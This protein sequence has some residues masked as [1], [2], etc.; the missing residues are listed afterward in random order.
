MQTYPLTHTVQHISV[1]N[2]A[3]PPLAASFSQQKQ[4]LNWKKKEN[5]ITSMH[6]VFIIINQVDTR[7][8]DLH[9]LLFCFPV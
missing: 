6:L 9:C 5:G 1:K 7:G 2:S 8:C 4:I 3:Q